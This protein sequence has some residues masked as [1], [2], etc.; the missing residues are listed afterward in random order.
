MLA[1]GPKLNPS[2]VLAQLLNFKDTPLKYKFGATYIMTTIKYL[3][4]TII[5]KENQPQWTLSY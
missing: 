5:Q 3:V 4:G 1:F 2:S